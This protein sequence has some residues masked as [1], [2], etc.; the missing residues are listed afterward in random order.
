MDFLHAVVIVEPH[1]N[2]RVACRSYREIVASDR[3]STD[4]AERGIAQSC[5]VTI[6]DAPVFLVTD[7]KIVVLRE[8][9]FSDILSVARVVETIK[10]LNVK[11]LIVGIV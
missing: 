4:I 2:V 1:I 6:L 7:N 10:F 9:S 3:V 5:D 11:A 8:V